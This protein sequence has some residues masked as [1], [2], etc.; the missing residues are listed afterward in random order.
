MADCSDGAAEK[1]AQAMKESKYTD[2]V[3][4]FAACVNAATANSRHFGEKVAELAAKND[5]G[6]GLEIHFLY[7]SGS[8]DDYYPSY[9][10]KAKP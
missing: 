7:N 3:E 5:G 10:F 1:T 9:T 6:I 4:T 8:G 2:A